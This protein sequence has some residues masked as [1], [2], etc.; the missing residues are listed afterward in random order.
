MYV[1]SDEIRFC[2]SVS[3][4]EAFHSMPT[5]AF[6]HLR[7]DALKCHRHP[8]CP[9][10]GSINRRGAGTRQKMSSSRYDQ[11]ATVKYTR[12]LHPFDQ[13]ARA[14]YT[15]QRFRPVFNRSW[16]RI[17]ILRILEFEI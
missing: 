17:S 9:L 8:A 12:V 5:G 3:L 1:Y 10:R 7:A 13:E 4:V 2:I 11:Q 15:R 6:L 16:A 14:R